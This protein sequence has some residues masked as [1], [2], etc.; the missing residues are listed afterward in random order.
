M[1]HLSRTLF[2]LMTL[3][4]MVSPVA[5]QPSTINDKV[6]QF[7]KD[8]RDE[9]VGKGEC[10]HLASAALKHAGAK[11]HTAFKD[12]PGKEDYVW[13]ELVYVLEMKEKSLKETKV[14]KKSIA[15]GDVIQFRDAVFKGKDLRGFPVYE[16]SCP[17]HTSVVLAVKTDEN[18]LTVLEQN[19][20]GKRK[21]LESAY[22]LTDLKSG[23]LR[24]YRP[25][26][27]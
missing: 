1:T 15:P 27:E 24:I 22:R 13:G 16:T 7:C 12:A 20:D 25:V 9:K 3:L 18:I 17:H 26:A 10:T 19:V 4:G 11:P 5:E 23:W 2:L 14:P 21:V 6:V 8:H